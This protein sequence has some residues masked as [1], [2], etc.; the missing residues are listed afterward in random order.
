MLMDKIPKVTWDENKEKLK[1][2]YPIITDDDVFLYEGKEKELIENLQYK[3]GISK[4]DLIAIINA[5]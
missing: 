5:F 4:L 1:Q 3:L 2:K